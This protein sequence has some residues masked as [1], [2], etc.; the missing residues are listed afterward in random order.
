MSSNAS[1]GGCTYRF[2]ESSLSTLPKPTKYDI[3][4]RQQPNRAKVSL[5]NERDRRPIEPAPILQLHWENC[6]DEE[7]KKC[8][9]SPFYFT[10]AN[11]VTEEDP[12][13]PLLPIQDYMSG[14]T[15]SSLYRLRDVDNSDGGFFV[16][17]D[18]AVKKEGKFKLRFS[19]FEI[20]DGQVE[21]KRTVL[22]DTFTVYIPKRFPGPVEATFLSRT[23]S[24]QGVKMR[25]R[26]EHRL[27]SRK[28]KS[29]SSTDTVPATKKYQSRKT[30]TLV[31]SS[32]PPYA[33][34]S[35]SVH[36]DVFFG[37]WQAKTTNKEPANGTQT[38]PMAE[39]LGPKSII[40]HSRQ[41]SD[42]MRAFPSPDSTI[43]SGCPQPS[44]SMSWEHRAQQPT[45]PKYS[46]PVG[47]AAANTSHMTS[48]Q[49]LIIANHLTDSPPPMAM[50]LPPPTSSLAKYHTCSDN[51]YKNNSSRLP[52]PPISITDI[53]SS[54]TGS[55]SWGT[56]LPPLRAIME[57]MRPQ[58]SSSSLFPLLLPPP[59]SMIDQHRYYR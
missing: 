52:S 12:E 7:I 58:S 16:F 38:P 4:I 13:T 45:E 11:L 35:A 22:S 21:N 29:E 14:S 9:Q 15:V 30:S 42:P 5:I 56:Q 54:A 41:R 6:S 8:L 55:H 18:L 46:W 25:I 40:Q 36:S 24:D 44:R 2:I 23:F 53:H 32:S 3:E 49:S 43:Y 1:S 28:R 26:K 19:L 39:D 10:V 51:S 31:T 59:V 50:Q 47:A 57:D 20:V 48:P 37:R 27:Q 17:G 34:A 33:D